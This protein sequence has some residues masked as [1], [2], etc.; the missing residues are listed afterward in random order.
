MESRLRYHW[1]PLLPDDGARVDDVHWGC[2]AAQR[3]DPVDWE[4]LI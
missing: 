4:T 2:F 1:R 3:I